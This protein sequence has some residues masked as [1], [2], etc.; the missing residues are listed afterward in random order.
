MDRRG[1]RYSRLLVLDRDY[2]AIRK[3]VW[4]LCRCDCGNTVSVAGGK[5][6]SGHT[7]S[8]GCLRV[9]ANKRTTED[10]TGCVFGR[11]S[12]SG[13]VEVGANTRWLANCSC[14]GKKTATRQYLTGSK[15]PSCGCAESEA[16][17]SRRFKDLTGK[18]F[19]LLEVREFVGFSDVARKSLWRCA[20]D[21]GGER[22]ARGNDLS[23]GRT[24]SCGCAQGAKLGLTPKHER[25]RSNL[26]CAKRR[27]RLRDAGGDGWTQ[28]DVNEVFRLQ[29]GLCAGPRC[30][31]PLG[32]HFHRDHRI[33]LALGGRH[34][35]DNL[36]LLCPTCN[37]RKNATDPVEWAQRHGLLI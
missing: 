35:R 36:E 13:P 14:G 10:L 4:W 19:G 34:D 16:S 21:C 29:R 23:S 12:V 1:E 25:D 5:L 11:L 31:K 32:D 7:K 20:C 3:G 8:C 30:G 18:R 26:Q 15:M 22:V 6:G 2:S 37:H 28:D 33:P 17:A 24:V 27:A 9:E